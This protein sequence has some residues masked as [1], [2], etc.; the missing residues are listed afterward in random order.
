MITQYAGTMTGI[1][2]KGT[3][4]VKNR[5]TEAL[6]KQPVKIFIPQWFCP[7]RPLVLQQVSPLHCGD[8]QS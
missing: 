7:D 2:H 1:M 4:N 8:P 3:I 5:K 6:K